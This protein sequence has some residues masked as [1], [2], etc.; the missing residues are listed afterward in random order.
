V[1]LGLGAENSPCGIVQ[2]TLTQRKLFFS[3][4]S[5]NSQNKFALS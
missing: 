5:E 1:E 3:I 2:A 4:L